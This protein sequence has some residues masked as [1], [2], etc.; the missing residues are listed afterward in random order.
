MGSG[1]DLSEQQ[2]DSVRELAEQI[3]AADSRFRRPIIARPESG[4]RAYSR[5]ADILVIGRPALGSSL[6]LADYAQWLRLRPQ[7]ARPGTPFWVVVP[8]EPEP[9]LQQQWGAMASGSSPARGFS[10]EQLR[11]I[12]YLSCV[13]GTR[14]LLFE[15]HTPLDATAP[16][17][18]M[19]RVI[20]ELLNLEF[21]LSEPWFAGGNFSL[22]AYSK[23]PELKDLQ[24]T[25]LR[26]DRG[27]LVIRSGWPR[28]RARF[29]VF[30]RTEPFRLTFRVPEADEAY[31]L[32]PGRLRRCR[33]NRRLGTNVTLDQFVLTA[34]IL[35]TQD[36]SFLPIAAA[37]QGKSA[38]V[39]PNCSGAW[40]N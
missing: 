29:P 14:G 25:V 33:H 27:Q 26:D 38:R 28:G 6:E 4:L 36:R 7:L 15:S 5:I 16:A 40:S 21:T 17:A 9:A 2:K 34:Q 22:M 10:A 37:R 30:R 18:E 12:T 11:L 19:R 31:E 35:F 23:D 8:T 1:T 24:A 13:S 3:R 32:V 20:L 39:P